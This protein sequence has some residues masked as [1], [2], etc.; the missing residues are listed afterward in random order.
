MAPEAWSQF[1]R[2]RKTPAS[3]V[4]GLPHCDRKRP[5]GW[6]KVATALHT[7]LR[8]QAPHN[9]ETEGDPGGPG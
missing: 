2:S 3:L 4:G 6:A 9:P 1:H 8:M 7:G 5:A